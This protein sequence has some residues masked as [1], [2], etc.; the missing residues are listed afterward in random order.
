MRDVVIL[1]STGSIGT[2]ALEVI[3]SRRDRFRVVGLAAGSSADLVIEQVRRFAPRIVAMADVQAAQR[4][5][6]ATGVEVWGGA[7]AATQLAAETCYV[8]L[9]GI[10]GAAGLRPTLATLG[11]GTTLA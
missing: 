3:D 1:G 4:V 8:V 7:D 10:T 9:N 5:R 2:Q 11:A 6:A